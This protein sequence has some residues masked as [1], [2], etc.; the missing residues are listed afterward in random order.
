MLRILVDNEGFII[1]TKKSHC[2]LGNINANDCK[3]CDN[4]PSMT[5]ILGQPKMVLCRG[6]K[7]LN[8]ENY[9]TLKI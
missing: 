4:C 1:N 3:N 7:E 2:V 8:I 6:K 5:T 9:L